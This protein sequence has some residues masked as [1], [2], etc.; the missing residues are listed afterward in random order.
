MISLG[1]TYGLSSS[2]RYGA[3]ASTMMIAMVIIP[4]ALKFIGWVC[5]SMLLM[6]FLIKKFYIITWGK[7]W[8]VWLVFFGMRVALA[9]ISWI[10]M[11]VVAF[12]FMAA[13]F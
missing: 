8:L 7:A 5:I 3:G 9:I 2:Y 10:V 12:A 13:M 4:Y 11:M 6:V 1:I